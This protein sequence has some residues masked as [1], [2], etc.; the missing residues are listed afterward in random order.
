MS[1]GHG[2]GLESGVAWRWRILLKKNIKTKTLWDCETKKRLEINGAKPWHTMHGYGKF[3]PS[4]K[5]KNIKGVTRS[6]TLVDHQNPSPSG[7]L[8]SILADDLK[9]TVS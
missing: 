7:A 2:N 8:D 6:W 9:S 4:E 5:G 3:G 1:L